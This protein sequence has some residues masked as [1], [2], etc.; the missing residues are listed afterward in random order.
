MTGRKAKLGVEGNVTWSG[1][2]TH[3]G[4]LQ[5]VCEDRKEDRKGRANKRDAVIITF[6]QGQPCMSRQGCEVHLGDSDWLQNIHVP[7]FSTLQLSILLCHQTNLA[8]STVHMY[9]R[10]LHGY[11]I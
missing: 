9:L 11:D 8:G 6:F 7:E 3:T 4:G 1:W 5:R 10:V 2:E